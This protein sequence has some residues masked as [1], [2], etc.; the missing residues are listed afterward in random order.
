MFNWSI[1]RLTKSALL[2]TIGGVIV[3]TTTDIWS[4]IRRDKREKD[5]YAKLDLKVDTVATNTFKTDKEEA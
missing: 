5:F 4:K 2:T 1:D 3:T